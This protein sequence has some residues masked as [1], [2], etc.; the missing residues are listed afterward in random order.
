MRHINYFGF[1]RH[2]TD[3]RFLFDDLLLRSVDEV[4]GGYCLR[5]ELLNGIHYISRLVEKDLADLR[6]PFEVLI[7]PFYDVRIMDE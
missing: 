6:R 2:Y 3:A 5:S 4:T 7:Q 1:G